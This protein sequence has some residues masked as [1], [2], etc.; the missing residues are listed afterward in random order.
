MTI[1]ADKSISRLVYS[2]PG[3]Y[4]FDFKVLVETDLTVIHTSATGVNTTLTLGVGYS[5]NINTLLN[6]GT[7]YVSS[8]PTTSGFL[9]IKRILPITQLV[10][11]RN[12]DA[13]NAEVLEGAFDRVVMILQQFAR[14]VSGSAA[15]SSTWRGAW[16]GFT[17]YFVGQQVTTNDNKMYVCLVS[18]NAGT[19]STDLASGYWALLFDFSVNPAAI[20]STSIG[21]EPGSPSRPTMMFDFANSKMLDPRITFLRYS[22]ATYVDKDGLIKVAAAHVPRFTHNPLTKECLGIWVEEPFTSFIALAHDGSALTLTNT[23]YLADQTKSP[24]GSVDADLFTEAATTTTHGAQVSKSYTTGFSHVV[25]IFVKR[26]AGGP[27][28]NFRIAFAASYRG[29]TATA[30]T[31]NLD[32]GVVTPTSGIP[33]V[34]GM[35]AYDNGWWRCWLVAPCTATGAHIITFLGVTTDTQV[36]T[37]L[38]DV[39]SGFYLWGVNIGVGA[40]V[41]SMMPTN[42]A[43]LADSVTV[44]SPW[45]EVTNPAAG[46]LIAT[47]IKFTAPEASFNTFASL[48]DGAIS[49]NEILLCTRDAT[50]KAM[51]WAAAQSVVA[52]SADFPGTNVRSKIVI[53]TTY[54]STII[55]GYA[56]GA[57]YDQTGAVMAPTLTQLTIGSRAGSWHKLNGAVANVAYWPHRLSS[58]EM[59]QLTQP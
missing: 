23:T 26:K 39:T 45:F 13:N 14:E 16:A 21:E 55:Q 33:P 25:S 36:T 1:Q 48:N 49:V 7:V 35:E 46:T 18:H 43:R 15:T 27:A 47:G 28:R 9:E 52:Q 10:D 42:E 31:F 12:N 32:T 53:G 44:A 57:L 40:V 59:I 11:W 22:S 17:Q 37:Y 3:G 30:A 20:P 38:G 2:G 24:S 19:F 4:P 29:G 41:T 8:A 51:V 6:T 50:D 56:N 5:V 54:D 58:A 34:Y